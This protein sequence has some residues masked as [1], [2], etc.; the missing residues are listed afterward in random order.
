MNNA[1]DSLDTNEVILSQYADDIGT[2][3]VG[4]TVAEALGRLQCGLD[5]L[6]QWCKRW[7]VTLN[8]LKSQ[9]VV[10][11]KCF[12]HKTEMENSTLTLKLFGQDIQIVSEAVFL[13]VTF[14]QRMTFKPQYKKI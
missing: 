2:W 8:P 12:R 11:T 5:L 4:E 10:F 14:D 7:F 9:L 6:E 1:T 13:G 3:A